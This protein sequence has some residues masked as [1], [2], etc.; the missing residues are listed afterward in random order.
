MLVWLCCGWGTGTQ[1]WFESTTTVPYYGRLFVA[2]SVST[3]L[4]G[5]HDIV[6]ILH[7]VRYHDTNPR[8]AIDTQVADPSPL[9]SCPRNPTQPNPTQPN[10]ARSR[11][12]VKAK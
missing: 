4:F 1:F 6:Q 8:Y 11:K 7:S 9:L 12:T 3:L 2:L 5:R 10:D